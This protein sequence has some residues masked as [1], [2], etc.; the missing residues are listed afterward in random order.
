MTATPRIFDPRACTLGEGPFWHPQRQQLFWFDIVNCRLLSRLGDQALE[1]RLDR[2]ASAAGWIDQDHLLLASETGLSRFNLVTGAEEMLCAIEADNP[3]TRSND[4]RADPWGGFW[5][6]T[7]S[8]AGEAGQGT[9]YRWTP[10]ELRGIETG[11]STP[12]AICFDADRACA[13]YADTKTR[14]IW[15]QPV[16]PVTGW[17]QGDKQVFVDLSATATSPEH[18]PDGA[19]IDAEGCLWSAQW[20]SARVARYSPEG[21]FLSAIDLPT[22]HTSCPAFGDPDLKTL[23]V[24]TALQKLPEDRPDWQATAGQVFAINTSYVGRPEPRVLLD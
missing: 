11:M 23:Y 1:W 18:K 15:R 9:L 14:I 20:G 13:Y 24:T 4:G 7:M 5:M 2:M 12:N 10:S 16:D 6:G 8:K 21:H 22:G 17:P 19:V 3:L